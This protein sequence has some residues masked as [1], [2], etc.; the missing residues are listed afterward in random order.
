[1]TTARSEPDVPPAPVRPL[2]QL[3]AVLFL[4]FT[5]NMALKK[6]LQGLPAS[7]L[8]AHLLPWAL[9]W[10]L[11]LLVFIPGFLLAERVSARTRRRAAPYA[12]V[13]LVGSVLLPAVVFSLLRGLGFPSPGGIPRP[14]AV[15]AFLDVLVRVGLAAVL[16]AEH[17]ER[18]NAVRDL[19]ALE[20]RR[21]ETL[22][23]L[24]ASRLQA[25]RVRV[26]PEGLIAELRGIR[27]AFVTDPAAGGA[28]LE[29]VIA[30]LRSA[31]RSPAP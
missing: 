3:G 19:Q 12:V 29:V 7:Q 1:M 16:Y 13:V 4:V 20:A 30:R 6:L 9:L 18:L 21:N 14:W 23:R 24:A 17:R 5:G 8:P 26:H 15:A 25:A 27:E 31:T 11:A 2:L 28:G 10:F 22:G